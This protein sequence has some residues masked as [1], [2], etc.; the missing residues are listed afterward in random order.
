[1]KYESTLGVANFDKTL[2]TVENLLK[3]DIEKFEYRVIVESKD[4]DDNVVKVESAWKAVKVVDEDEVAT[5]QEVVLKQ[6]TKKVDFLTKGE[7]DAV[8]EVTKVKQAN[9]KVITLKNNEADD[10]K[11]TKAVSSN[12]DVAYWDGSAVVAVAKGTATFKL[13]LEK[14]D[15][16]FEYSIRVVVKDEQVAR[17]AVL[18]DSAV[19]YALND[20][21]A[22]V[23]VLIK[24]QNG[25]VM[26][27]INDVEGLIVS[28]N[29]EEV[30]NANIT[31]YTGEITLK[32]DLTEGTDFKA[33]R[34]TIKLT[35]K[36]NDKNVRLGEFTIDVV[37]NKNDAVKYEF[38]IDKDDEVKELDLYDG[39]D[40]RTE[41]IVSVKATKGGVVVDL[42]SLVPGELELE[43][44]DDKNKVDLTD[45]AEWANGKF[46]VKLVTTGDDKTKVGTNVVQLV[47]T[48]GDKK[49]V[50]TSISI[51]VVNTA[52]QVTG[53]ALVGKKL[54][55]DDSLDES[56]IIAAIDAGRITVSLSGDGEYTDEMI[57]KAVYI[58][59]NKAVKITVSELYGGKVFT[60]TGVEL[61]DSY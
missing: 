50:V 38:Y 9:G 19:K 21:A 14:G 55:G 51:K 39:E 20:A 6:A 46:T 7:D 44:K 58:K 61:V 29:G 16:K 52:P 1:M 25:D 30:N 48:T 28:F 13:T 35:H 42:D 59:S 27:D 43:P 45:T 57:E 31:G 37:N 36:V 8:F 33:G 24:D 5:I 18:K 10:Y 26:K 3:D 32:V 11:V 22:E 60:L 47:K 40:D 41:I 56:H 4:E 12:T 15:D 49:E 54:V 53:I 34:K 17:T 2:G 23:V